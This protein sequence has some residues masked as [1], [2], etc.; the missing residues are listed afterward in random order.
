MGGHDSDDSV[1]RDA[2]PTE[3]IDRDDSEAA[4]IAAAGLDPLTT[5]ESDASFDPDPER[6]ETLREIAAEI[7][8]DSSESKQVAAILYRISDL[9]DESEDTSPVEIYHNVKH[10]M[11]TKDR[12]G[13]RR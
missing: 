4:A 8:G 3:D 5:P 6:V 2:D 7:R 13:L 10:I 11:L 1:D 12:G 9:Y